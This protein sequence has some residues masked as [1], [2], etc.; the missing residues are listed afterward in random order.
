MTPTSMSPALQVAVQ[1]AVSPSPARYLSLSM[2]DR[3]ALV[4]QTKTPSPFAT[5]R[6]RPARYNWF[7]RFAFRPG[8]TTCFEV[9][10]LGE[11]PTVPRRIC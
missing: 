5:A 3:Y 7:S 10:A 2:L 1:V 4:Y 6:P 8:V 9:G 11:L